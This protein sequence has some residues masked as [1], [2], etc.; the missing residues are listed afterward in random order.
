M[1]I[2]HG[3]PQYNSG[4][5]VMM[6]NGSYYKIGVAKENINEVV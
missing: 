6:I 4:W 3:D 5:V 1:E 2:H